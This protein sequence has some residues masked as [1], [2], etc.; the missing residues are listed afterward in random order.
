MS[1]IAVLFVVAAVMEM[2]CGHVTGAAVLFA[3]AAM[4]VGLAVRRALR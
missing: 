4:L 3:G 2:A 1:A